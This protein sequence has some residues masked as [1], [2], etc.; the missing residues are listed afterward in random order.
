MRNVIFRMFKFPHAEGAFE[1]FENLHHSKISRYTVLISSTSQTIVSS[2]LKRDRHAINAR[3]VFVIVLQASGGTI[4]NL[5]MQFGMYTA[6]AQNWGG[7]SVQCRHVMHATPHLS[8]RQLQT[9][10]L[11]PGLSEAT[12]SDTYAELSA[13]IRAWNWPILD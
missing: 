3:L 12:A 7:R 11:R 10:A 1:K 4:Q 6:A 2:Y 5:G 9:H 8:V 13:V